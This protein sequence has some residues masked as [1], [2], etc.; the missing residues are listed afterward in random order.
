MNEYATELGEVL[1]TFNVTKMRLFILDHIEM[2]RKFDL[3]LLTDDR[4]VKGMMAKMILARTDMPEDLK[5]KA[6]NV[7]DRMGWDYEINPNN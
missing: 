3:N 6:R 1:K 4:F 2:Y 5:S 7:L